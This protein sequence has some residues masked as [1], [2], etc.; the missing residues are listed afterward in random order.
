M[1]EIVVQAEKAILIKNDRGETAWIPQLWVL[2]KKELSEHTWEIE[3]KQ[4]QW[5]EK[6]P[7][8]PKENLSFRSRH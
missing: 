5:E 6:L 7:E 2:K 4:H 1:V 8:V 3:I